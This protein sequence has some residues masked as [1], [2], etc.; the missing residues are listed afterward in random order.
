MDPPGRKVVEVEIF[1]QFRDYRRTETWECDSL[2]F[3]IEVYYN[4]HAPQP[5]PSD[6]TLNPKPQNPGLLQGLQ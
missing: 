2:G 4:V 1:P 6:E 5:Y 3:S